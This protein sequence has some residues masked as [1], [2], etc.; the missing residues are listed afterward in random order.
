MTT[1]DE[2]LTKYLTDAHSI[3]VQAIAQLKMAPEIAVDPE[4]ARIFSDHLAET[5]EQERAVRRRLEARDAG[6]SRVKDIVMGA[7]GVGFALF[8]KF[9]PDTPGKLAAHAY[10][11]EHLELAGYELLR[12]VAERAGDEE[13]AETASEIAEQERAMGERIA[14]LW[15]RAVDAS[16]AEVG[17]DSAGDRLLGYLADAH[18]IENQAIQL[19]ERGPKIVGDDELARLFAE[20]LQETREHQRLIDSQLEARGGSSGALKDAAMR[21]GGLN[22]GAFFQAQPDT[23]GKLAAFAYAF[24]HL[25]I[26]GYEQLKRVAS[27]A[28][29]D[30]VVRTAQ[31]ILDEERTAASKL[32]AAFDGAVESSLDA[33][34]VAAR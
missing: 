23:P 28:G 26:G 8:A 18:A 3:E 7:G 12:R 20:H 19:L 22:W 9:Q 6:P 21:M 29:D 25:E 13:T 15:D 16:L 17:A 32:E 30:S 10:S 1:L 24:E 2:Q 4:L 34:G 27:R 5:E 14:G 33:L 11:Y 31:R